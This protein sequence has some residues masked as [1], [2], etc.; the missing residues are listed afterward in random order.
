MNTEPL[1]PEQLKRLADLGFSEPLNRPEAEER[2]RQFLCAAEM[3]GPAFTPEPHQ[4]WRLSDWIL[5][6]MVAIISVPGAIIFAVV[7]TMVFGIMLV[8]SIGKALWSML[9]L[10]R[11]KSE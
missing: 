6:I 9:P 3:T 11:T 8:I 4:P 5:C 10:T 2:A 1:T 7:G